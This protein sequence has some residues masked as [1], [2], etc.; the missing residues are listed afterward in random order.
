MSRQKRDREEEDEDDKAEK[1][2]HR[3]TK[4]ERV[5][6]VR[7]SHP[8]TALCIHEETDEKSEYN[9]QECMKRWRGQRYWYDSQ[10]SIVQLYVHSINR[11]FALQ[12]ESGILKKVSEDEVSIPDTWCGD[13][14]WV[15][16]GD[17]YSL[18]K[19]SAGNLLT[20]QKNGVAHRDGDLPD[21]VKRGPVHFYNQEPPL[22]PLRI[23]IN[24]NWIGKRYWQYYDQFLQEYNVPVTINADGEKHWDQHGLHHRDHDRSAFVQYI[25]KDGQ[26]MAYEEKCYQHGYMHTD[27][28]SKPAQVWIYGPSSGICYYKHGQYH[29]MR[30]PASIHTDIAGRVTKDYYIE[31]NPVEQKTIDIIRKAATGGICLLRRSYRRSLLL[32]TRIP[33]VIIDQI[34]LK[35]LVG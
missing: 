33:T 25:I 14:W 29:S 7:E 16:K 21:Y 4:I 20:Y 31:G 18:G 3:T 34:V 1:K 32:Y 19:H 12:V 27:D 8:K 35:F 2:A 5:D 11:E 13:I 28:R 24:P 15:H 30:G 23:W 9:E 26:V 22:S 10:G 17:V 6:I